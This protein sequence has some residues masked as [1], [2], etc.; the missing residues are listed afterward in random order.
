[1]RLCSF[2][3]NGK[4]MSAFKMGASSFPAF[5][6]LDSYVNKRGLACT[7]DLGAIPPGRYY[8]LDRP[9]GGRLGWFRD[10][11]SGKTDWFALYAIDGNIDDETW[12]DKVKRGQFRLHPKGFRGVSKGCIVLD[13]EAD[14]QLLRARLTA[15]Q[16]FILLR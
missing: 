13:R 11:S 8:I 7:P 5:S 15:Q 6:G 3:L 10:L 14:F 9:S 2:E 1:M 16:Q 4:P 12:C